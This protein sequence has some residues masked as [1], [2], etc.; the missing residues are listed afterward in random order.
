MESYSIY[1]DY[2][3]ISQD[4]AIAIVP[5][6]K[7]EI[8]QK[9]TLNE[10]NIYPKGQVNP[11]E[12]N[13]FK[14][15]F[16]FEE[17]KGLFYD[18]TLITFPVQHK[19]ENFMGN[20]MPSQ[21]NKL[22]NTVFEMAAEIM[23]I[24]RYIH[25]NFDSASNLPEQAGYIYGINSGFILY[26]PLINSY[27]FITDKYYAS[28][29]A[30]GEGL[31]TRGQNLITQYEKYFSILLN[32]NSETANI[33]KHALS[34]YSGI[35]YLPTST[36]KFVHAMSLIEYLANPY[37]YEKMQDAKK[38]IIP[39]SADSQSHYLK[40]VERFK[41]LTSL[42]DDAGNQIGLRTS[43]VHNGKTLE[44]IFS[45]DYEIV[46]LLRELQ[47]Y[48]CNYINALIPHCNESWEQVATVVEQKRCEIQTINDGYDGKYEA[49]VAILVDVPFLNK[50]IE[51]VYIWYPQYKDR[52]FEITNFLMRLLM[53]CDISRPGYQIPVH[54]LYDEDTSLKGCNDKREI[55]E[56]DGLGFD[57]PYG[58]LSIYTID[59]TKSYT[60]Q[61]EAVLEV[62]LSEVNYNISPTSKYSKIIWVSDRNNMPDDLFIHAEQIS[63]KI[64]LGRL[65]NKRTTCFDQCTYFD[66]QL[67][68][69]TC[70][71][72]P[73]HEE[74]VDKFIFSV[75]DG[76]YPGA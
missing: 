27:N 45:S 36:S 28:N 6:K 13:S 72:I 30:I 4:Y 76:K 26:Y 67:L 54:I 58:E 46:L 20:L 62:L 38:K 21:K 59:A 7:F 16:N 73:H 75:E 18:S 25:S 12:K 11:I 23:D 24:F 65:D 61:L 47:N 17:Q 68:I 42:N 55:S 19:S 34:L 3:N 33:L 31:N 53:Q 22:M 63:K 74:C 64:F 37:K 51:E 70:L 56:F 35:L 39:F 57:S 29:T 50:A 52:R 48:I 41:F 66:I 32:R 1:D 44:Q 5:V 9:I 10:I 49:D 2:K 71:D 43:I 14:F 40:L 60:P 69:M 8:L 15:D